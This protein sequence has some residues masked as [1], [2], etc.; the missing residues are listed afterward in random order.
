[1]E[2]VDEPEGRLVARL[3]QMDDDYRLF[4]LDRY[5]EALLHRAAGDEE[6]ATARVKYMLE[7]LDAIDFEDSMRARR[8]SRPSWCE[9]IRAW[10]NRRV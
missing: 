6:W 5:V 4:W 3:S 10:L 7:R 8:L 9:R 1:M 2:D